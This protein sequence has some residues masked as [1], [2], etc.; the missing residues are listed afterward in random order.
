MSHSANHWN[1][2][3]NHIQLLWPWLDAAEKQLQKEVGRCSNQKE[4]LNEYDSHQVNYPNYPIFSDWIP[5][6]CNVLTLK[7]M[8]VHEYRGSQPCSVTTID[9]LFVLIRM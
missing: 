5:I 7:K 3:Q 1:Q 2:Y 9:G 8:E 4:A 6:A